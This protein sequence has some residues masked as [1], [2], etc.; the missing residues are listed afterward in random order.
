MLQH[1]TPSEVKKVPESTKDL[2][3]KPVVS[4]NGVEVAVCQVKVLCILS[5]AVCGPHRTADSCQMLCIPPGGL[6]SVR[7]N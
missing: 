4:S 5:V 7:T 2:M 6:P 3:K 1:L